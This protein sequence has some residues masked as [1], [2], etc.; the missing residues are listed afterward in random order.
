MYEEDLERVVGWLEDVRIE[1]QRREMIPREDTDGSVHVRIPYETM[2][3]NPDRDQ[4][5]ARARDDGRI[6]L[7][8]GGNEVVGVADPLDVE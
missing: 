2:Q 3:A 4:L 1:E 6:E 7:L 5:T 8:D